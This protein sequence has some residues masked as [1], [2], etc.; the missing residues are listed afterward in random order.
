MKQK[1]LA[2][3]TTVTA[4]LVCSL[5][6]TLTV[7]AEEYPVIHREDVVT[8]LSEVPDADTDENGVWYICDR[9]GNLTDVPFDMIYENHRYELC[10]YQNGVGY[11]GTA[12][13][14]G[15]EWKF[16]N[17]TA[18]NGIYDTDGD[19]IIDTVY[20]NGKPLYGFYTQFEDNFF[21]PGHS[22][23]YTNKYGDVC[24]AYHLC[25]TEEGNLYPSGWY[26][27]EDDRRYYEN[28]W[29][30]N[31]YS[32]EQGLPFTG[33]CV[34]K[35]YSNGY[36]YDIRYY[37]DGEQYYGHHTV[38]QEDH[39][40]YQ[41]RKHYPDGVEYWN[42]YLEVGKTY[43]FSRDKSGHDVLHE[44]FYEENGCKYWY[45]KGLRQGTEGRGKEIYDPESD[46]WYW[47]DA[48]DNGKVAV[49]KDVY[50][51]SNGGKW[52]RYDENGHMIKGWCDAEA[53]TYYFDLET[54][55]MAKGTVTIGGKEYTFDEN[56]GIL[57]T[58]KV[59]DCEWVSVNGKDYWYEN[60]VRQGYDPDNPAYRG[61][62]IYDPA[63]DAWY[64]LDN[65]QQGAKAVSKDVYQESWAGNLGENDGYG[66][67]VRYDENGH[68]VKGWDYVNVKNYTWWNYYF[69]LETG[70][71]AKGKVSIIVDDGDALYEYIYLFDEVD[72]H[73]T[74]LISYEPYTGDREVGS[75]IRLE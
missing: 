22:D 57:T 15:E 42:Q 28:G 24:E 73:M 36:K 26:G 19:G 50:Q 56:T 29:L 43:L 9:Y 18:L 53:G 55:A 62:E 60:G 35:Y 52:V 2:T 3:L 32:Y 13:V 75:A 69:D 67:W 38:T 21:L 70:A 34:Y 12:I 45:E 54:G 33:F 6:L 47:L 20:Y 74:E 31:D 64:W 65:V 71:M 49:S 58:Q 11:T 51:E 7:F 46:A 10:F 30:Y 40:N 41:S 4:A 68:M 14:D 48:V 72:G 59:H 44:G 37:I 63:S 25:Y 23:S 61:K 17:G 16:E 39:W 8:E 27:P 66:K 1:I 5:A